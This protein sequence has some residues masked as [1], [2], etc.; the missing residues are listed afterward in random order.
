MKT[1]FKKEIKF[2]PG[3]D[4]IYGIPKKDPE[5]G[6]H[7]MQIRFVLIG[8]KGAV[9]FFMFTDWLPMVKQ[10]CGLYK[11]TY[12]MGGSDCFPMAVDIGYHS[13]KPIYEGQPERKNCE[14]LKGKSCYYDGSGLYAE[15]FMAELINKGQDALW[16]K[17]EKYYYEVFKRDSAVFNSASG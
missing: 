14:F 17:M 12:S 1:I 8:K 7:G 3:Y 16:E 9:Q 5:Y 13:P 11:P 10:G 4:Y 15:D 6:R 2:E